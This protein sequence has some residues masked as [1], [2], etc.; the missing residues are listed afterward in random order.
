MKLQELN[1]RPDIKDNIKLDAS[2][3]QLAKLLSLL[4][5]RELPDDIATAI[6]KDIEEINAPSL[7]GT[8]L[9]KQIRKKQLE[10]IQLLEKELKL[11]TK[12]H[13]RTTWMAISLAVFGIPLGVVFGVILG[14]MAFIGIGIPVGMAIG[15]A[16]GTKMDKKA[17]EEGRQLDLELK[18]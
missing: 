10:I 1:Q 14:N 9:K 18:P 12:N 3:N 16:V 2:Y 5:E 11:V 17:L 6:N 15:I 8:M 4:A 7:S 13:Y